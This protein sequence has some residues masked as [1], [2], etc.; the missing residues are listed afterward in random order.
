[1]INKYLTFPQFNP[2]IISLGPITL[3]WY[4]LMYMLGLIFTLWFAMRQADSKW[5]KKEIEQLIY[6]SFLGMI[7]GGRIGYIIFY[8]FSIFLDEPFYLFKIWHGGMSFHGGLIGTIIVMIWFAYR[9]K[10][11][12]FQVTD[13]IVPIVPFGLGA[14]RLGNFI[15]GELW[16]RVAVNIPWAML[17]PNSKYEDLVLVLNN[18]QLQSIFNHYGVL[19]RHPSQLYELFFEGIILF[20]ILNL[21]IRKKRPLASVSGLFLI[22]YGLLR[23]IIEFFRQPDS[24]LGLFKGII[25]MGQILSLPM[26]ISGLIIIVWSY[27]NYYNK[28]KNI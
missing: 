25:S 6:I 26:I 3:H 4:G 20:I 15:N 28:H 14:G 12:F 19:P 8:N 24:Q 18:P 22:S 17:F 1:M 23:T 2:I 16:G 27:Q 13:F 9:T 11:D 10:R 7:I 5:S 21:F